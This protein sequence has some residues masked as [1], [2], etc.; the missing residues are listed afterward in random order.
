MT[1]AGFEVFLHGKGVPRTRTLPKPKNTSEPRWRATLSNIG[2]LRPKRRIDSLKP[3]AGSSSQEE[4]ST[5]QEDGSTTQEDGSTTQ[6]DNVEDADDKRADEKETAK[7]DNETA[8]A[9]KDTEKGSD[10]E[11]S[12]EGQLPKE[13]DG[14]SEEQKATSFSSRRFWWLIDSRPSN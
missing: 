12:E 10:S 7:D 8:K 13:D 9:V 11:D 4:G 14:D 1:P 2:D 6:D 3:A 5:T